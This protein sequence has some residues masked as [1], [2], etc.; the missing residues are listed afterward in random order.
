MED[1]RA[2]DSQSLGIFTP[3]KGRRGAGHAAVPVA[4]RCPRCTGWWGIQ[5]FRARAT[6]AVRPQDPAVYDK[7]TTFFPD[8]PTDEDGGAGAE[9]GGK[10]PRKQ[11]P[12]YLKDM[13]A[14]QV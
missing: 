9:E 6:H 8:E 13:I 12:L 1:M 5:V 10:G 4:R 2:R 7:A 3:C 14:K 11:R